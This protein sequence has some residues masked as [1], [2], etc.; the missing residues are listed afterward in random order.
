MGGKSGVADRPRKG[1]G[2]AF[3]AE[4]T[5]ET[6]EIFQLFRVKLRRE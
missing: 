6:V 1:R 4:K 3:D 2:N 5:V